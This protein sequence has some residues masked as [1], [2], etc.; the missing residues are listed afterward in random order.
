MPLESVIVS[1]TVPAPAGPQVTMI[2]AS[3][4]PGTSVPPNTDQEYV[5]LLL[6]GTNSV[7]SLASRYPCARS[8]PSSRKISNCF[9]VSTPSETT[10]RSSSLL[11]ARMART[12][13]ILAS[14]GRGSIRVR[15]IFSPSSGNIASLE[16]D[17]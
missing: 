15:S 9:Q 8:Q 5:L 11:T 12:M 16:K 2:S 10:R 4:E 17:E 6:Y 3:F 13:P 14:W 1:V 7:V